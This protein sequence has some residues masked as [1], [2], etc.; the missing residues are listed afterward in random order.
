MTTNLRE[1][2][3]LQKEKVHKLDQILQKLSVQNLP[4]S[5]LHHFETVTNC[6]KSQS[7]V[8]STVLDHIGLAKTED[9]LV[10]YSAIWI[11]QPYITPNCTNSHLAIED[12][13]K[14]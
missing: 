6:Y 13:I 3:D 4:K 7:E 1:F 2:H 9:E 8:N 11:Q 5:T 10:Y 12:F 14:S